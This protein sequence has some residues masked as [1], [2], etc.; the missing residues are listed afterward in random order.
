MAGSVLSRK[1]YRVLKSSGSV[2]AL[3]ICRERGG[4]VNLLLTDI[5]MPEMNGKELADKLTAEY[6]NIR[7]LFMSGYPDD[8]LSLQSTIGD[9]TSYIQKPFTVNG[10]LH[11]I[12]ETLDG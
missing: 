4:T 1:G 5:V 10:L 6:E 7:V 11:K 12:R 3:N 2:E 8:I 9:E